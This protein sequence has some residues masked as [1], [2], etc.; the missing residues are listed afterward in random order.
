VD[1][2]LR[3][4]AGRQGD[5]G[6][7][8]FFVSLEDE[9]MRL[10]GSERIASLM[11][12]MGHKEGEVLQHSMISRSIERAQKK[13]EENNF[14]IR[15]RL[16]EYDDV[17]NAQ[18]DVIYKRRHH[19]LF[20]DRLSLD[21]DNAMFDVCTDLAMQFQDNRDAEAFR[22]EVMKHLAIEPEVTTEEFAKADLNEIGNRL[23]G[24]ARDFYTRKMDTLR[25]NMH[26][27]LSQILRENGERVE[28]IVIPFTDGIRGI[29]VYV[30][31]KEA[32]AQEARPVVRSL[33]KNMT[34][35]IIDDSWKDHLRAM[36]DLRHSVQMAS[37][38]QKD[39]LLI[40]KFEAFNLFKQMLLE[41]NR[42]IVS[43]LLRAGIPMQ[44]APQQAA[45]IPE[46]R[47]DMS[48]MR[49]NRAEIDAAG[50]DYAADENDYYNNESQQPA[51]KRSPVQAG[52][53]IGRNDP[54]PCGSGK[55]YKNCHGK[56]LQ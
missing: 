50:Q 21:I 55:K 13:V 46:Q 48:Q 45:Q 51:V 47:T 6:T 17:M 28:N 30:G 54:C 7:S 9:L 37:Y 12:K 43:F 23:Y 29:Q 8:Q 14:G 53:K 52:P 19:A 22:L 49:D 33:E 35:A 20:G 11:D 32:V 2:Q 16:L 27:T 36:D 25:E 5:P 34:L 40:Y 42:N 1:R 31:L 15:K 41:T 18:R 26:P 56:G 10:F 3:G 38:E 4:R 39:P 44:E 24:Q